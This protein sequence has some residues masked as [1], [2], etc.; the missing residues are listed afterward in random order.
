MEAA[1]NETLPAVA[2]HSVVSCVVITILLRDGV[3]MWA[4]LPRARNISVALIQNIAESP[5]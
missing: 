4:V 1:N 3:I 2:G 5:L